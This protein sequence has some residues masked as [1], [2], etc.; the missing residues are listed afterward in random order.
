MPVNNPKNQVN[1]PKFDAQAKYKAVKKLIAKLET[2]RSR[3]II[4]PD[5]A[6]DT[7]E[8]RTEA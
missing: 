5:A 7:F 1:A 6:D 8:V 2:G 4:L 3:Q